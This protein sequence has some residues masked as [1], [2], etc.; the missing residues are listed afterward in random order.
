LEDIR[1]T[2]IAIAIAIA[3][4]AVSTLAVNEDILIMDRREEIV[5][6]NIKVVD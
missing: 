6:S 2:A 1:T 4:V 5:H 3:V